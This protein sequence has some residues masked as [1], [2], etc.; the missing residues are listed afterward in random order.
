MLTGN[1]PGPE[2][3]E[4]DGSSNPLWYTVLGALLLL[5]GMYDISGMVRYLVYG[6]VAPS[7]PWHQPVP[8]KKMALKALIRIPLPFIFIVMFVRSENRLLSGSL[9]F[10]VMSLAY[11]VPRQKRQEMQN[12]TQVKQELVEERTKQKKTVAE[13]K[14]ETKRKQ[15]AKEEKRVEKMKAAEEEVKRIREEER[16][17]KMVEEEIVRKRDEAERVR[18]L[19][20]ENLR[21]AEEEK[22]EEERKKKRAKK[23]EDAAKERERRRLR[24]GEKKGEKH[25]IERPG[26]RKM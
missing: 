11:H 5:C 24:E 23:R 16:A 1:S 20:Q 12:D 10:I 14:E 19:K 9:A 4:Q 2:G 25:E 21:K 26:R 8:S 18:Q 17:I 22:E 13:K 6:G 15:K 7:A 3:G